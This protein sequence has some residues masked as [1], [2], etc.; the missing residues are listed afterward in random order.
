MLSACAAYG[1]LRYGGSDSQY[2]GC[3]PGVPC[4]EKSD[5][6]GISVRQIGNWMGKKMKVSKRVSV[7]LMACD[8]GN[9]KDKAI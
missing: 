4:V 5:R 3:V 1:V 6:Q 9:R 2:A 7:V 8:S